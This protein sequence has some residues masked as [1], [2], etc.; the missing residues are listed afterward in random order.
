MSETALGP[1]PSLGGLRRRLD[2]MSDG[3]PL[4]PLV[5][6]SLLFFFD[7]WDT[8]AFNVLA[9]NIKRAFGLSTHDFGLIV[10]VNISMVLLAAVPLGYLGDRLPRRRLVMGGAIVAGVFSF[11]TGFPHAV[12]LLVVFR[13]GN[14]VGRLVND[15]IHP[16]LLSDYYRPEDR[17]AIF[18]FHRNSVYAA[19]IVGAAVAGAVSALAGWRI[20]FM[21]LVVPI[22]VMA[23]V[24][25]RLADVRRGATDDPELSAEATEEPPPEFKEASRTLL[26]V[27]TL[28][29][30]YTAWFFIGPGLIPLSYLLPLYFERVYKLGDFPRGLIVAANAA[31]TLAGVL[32]ASRL[33]PRW[34]AE[35]L[36]TPLERAGRALV[37]IGVGLAL[38]AIS[39]A[40]VVAVAVSLA[41]S[42]VAGFFYPPFFTVQALVSPARVRSLSFSFGLLFI[43]AGAWALFYGLGLAKIA[44][45]HGYRWGLATLLPYWVI[46]GL[47]LRSARRFVA[48]D[49]AK[50][51]R[52]LASTVELRHQ[53]LAAGRRSLLRC[54]GVDVAYDSVQVLFGV[55]LEVNEGEI[56]A[57]LGTNGAGKSTLLKAISGLVDP[58]GGAIFFDGVD[59]THADAR[60]S[61]QAGIV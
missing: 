25:V 38:V 43:V 35:D 60:R 28:K 10:L 18:G 61:V 31:A 8:A 57:L 15:S 2:R 13:L 37:G 22:L 51:F 40:L 55:D 47:V 53:R 36:G 44:D 54:V 4:F 46:G 33:T 9:P 52:V 59:V 17:P 32:V 16:S 7:E 42:F 24:A 45:D 58:A 23:V 12:A 56:V 29:R 20:A 19:A 21:V 3:L 26:A 1:I 30:Q 39:P 14:G 34:L 11:L 48:D 6:L 50:A 41:T 27:P 49:A 5:V